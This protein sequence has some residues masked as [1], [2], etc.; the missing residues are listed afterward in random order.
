MLLAGGGAVWEDVL[1]R[2]LE[3]VERGEGPRAHL[4]NATFDLLFAVAD[5]VDLFSSFEHATNVLRLSL[6]GGEPSTPTGAGFVDSATTAASCT[7]VVS[8]TDVVR[9]RTG[10]GGGG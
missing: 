3:L 9:L 1:G 8:G 2:G 4:E 10:Q 6:F 7:V 5:D